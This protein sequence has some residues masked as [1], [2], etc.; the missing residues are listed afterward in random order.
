MADS[1]NR[2]VNKSP[3]RSPRPEERQRDPERTRQALLDAALAEFAAKGRAG[4]RVSEIAER[5]GVSKQLISYYFGGKDG[6]YEALV[7]RWL[8]QEAEFAPRELPLDQL[9]AR[10]IRDGVDHRDMHRLLIREGIEGVATPDA[11]LPSGDE[12]ELGE[13]ADLRRR[14]AEGEIAED[15]DP[16]LL[17]LMLQGV[18]SA[19]VVYAAD[20]RKLTGLDPASEEFAERYGD[21]V[22]RVMARLSP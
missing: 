10:Y 19:G 5:A 11:D 16:A 17:M 12:G 7:E 1:L 21:L 9:V 18:A 6:L 15:L 3:R 4:A 8:A 20:V 2:Q 22:R 13:V 14:Q